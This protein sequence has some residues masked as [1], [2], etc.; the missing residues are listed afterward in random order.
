MEARVARRARGQSAL[1]RPQVSREQRA[2]PPRARRVDARQDAAADRP[3]RDQHHRGVAVVPARLPAGRPRLHRAR[4]QRRADR[5][6]GRRAQ[7]RSREE[8]DRAHPLRRAADHVH[9]FQHEG[10]AGRRLLER[11][12]RAAPR[13]RDG[14]QR[15][16][17]D[18]GAVRRPGAAREP[19]AA[20]RCRRPRCLAAG[21][22]DLRPGGRARAARPLRLQ[23]P[24]RRRLSRDARRQAAHRRARHA[25]GLVVP[26]GR[27]AV[28]EEHGRHRHPDGSRAED[29]RRAP[30]PEPRRQAAD[31]QP[32]LPLAR[33]VGLPD[34]ADRCGASRRSTPIRRNSP[35][36]TT[37]RRTSSSCA[38]RPV[39]RG[40]R[41]R[42]RCPRSRRPTCR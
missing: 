25:A 40:S 21:E 39:P 27:H 1:P 20:A 9:L 8:G 24:R 19:A 28:E 5:A 33:A 29:L 6:R 3:H 11:A 18:Q 17:A 15:R 35:T 23:G 16:R 32:R 26:R 36:P 4:R 41:W 7:A 14:L 13:D 10:P 2:A 12:G 37:T 30:Q 42:A 22:V 31:V 38:R 34:P